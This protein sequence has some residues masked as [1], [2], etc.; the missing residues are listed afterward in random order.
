MPSLFHEIAQ[1]AGEHCPGLAWP[2]L[3][4]ALPDWR[5]FARFRMP[6]A[7]YRLS[8]FDDAR[9][10]QN[11]AIVESRFRGASA[12]VQIRFAMACAA[13]KKD[14]S[15]RVVR[16]WSGVS[17]WLRRARQVS[18]LVEDCHCRIR[19]GPADEGVEAASITVFALA[20]LPGVGIP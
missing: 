2:R 17:V 20:D 3:L 16:A 19:R 9:G 12:F 5:S 14:G 11:E 1:V 8:G 6:I 7:G 13:S 10:R 4:R 15:L 18:R